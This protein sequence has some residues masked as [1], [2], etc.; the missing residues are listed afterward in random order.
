M[1]NYYSQDLKWALGTAWPLHCGVFISP[2]PKT[3]ISQPLAPEAFKTFSTFLAFTQHINSIL[4]N[5][6]S[7]HLLPQLLHLAPHFQLLFHTKLFQRVLGGCYFRVLITHSL[8]SQFWVHFHLPHST[9]TAP[10][11]VNTTSSCPIHWPLLLSSSFLC[12]YSGLLKQLTS[13]SMKC[14]LPAPMTLL[15][16]S[17]SSPH[18]MLPGPSCLHYKGWHA[19]V[20]CSWSFSVYFLK[21]IIEVH[22]FTYH[23]IHFKYIIQ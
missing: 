17:L 3:C 2:L 8:L 16:C 10:M 23:N 1:L 20:L 6:E 12:K 15:F 9:G 18:H 11:R 19:T 21:N 5:R 7:P 14:S 22:I 13:S 4:K